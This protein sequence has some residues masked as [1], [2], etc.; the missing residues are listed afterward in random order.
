MQLTEARAVL[1]LHSPERDLMVCNTHRVTASFLSL[2][3]TMALQEKGW[4][5]VQEQCQGPGAQAGLCS[6]FCR[7]PGAHAEG[8]W[9][10]GRPVPMAWLLSSQ[11]GCN[12]ARRT[13]LEHEW[14]EV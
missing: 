1:S 4:E 12:L 9:Q 5:K 10:E 8:L 6:L 3:T 14:W 2:K 11:L 13:R 7:C